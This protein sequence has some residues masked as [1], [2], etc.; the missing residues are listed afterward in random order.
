MEVFGKFILF[1]SL[2]RPLVAVVVYSWPVN[3]GGPLY[4]RTRF[5]KMAIQKVLFWDTLK[6]VLLLLGMDW[7]V[8]SRQLLP[9]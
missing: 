3:S 7:A 8:G 9:G 6:Y 2:T 1:G 5:R 4:P